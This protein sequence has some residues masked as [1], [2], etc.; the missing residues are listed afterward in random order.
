MSNRIVLLLIIAFVALT[1]GSFIWFVVTWDREL[2]E[3]VTLLIE[4]RSP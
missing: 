4:E 1:L 3:P 2:E